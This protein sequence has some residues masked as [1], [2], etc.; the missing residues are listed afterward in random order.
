MS[1]HRN[2]CAHNNYFARGSVKFANFH[3]SFFH[4]IVSIKIMQNLCQAITWLLGICQKRFYTF[5]LIQI[6]SYDDS[7]LSVCLL[8]ITDSLH[9]LKN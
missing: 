3:D 9:Y 8:L 4:C 6:K 1:Q 2:D 7:N 5:P